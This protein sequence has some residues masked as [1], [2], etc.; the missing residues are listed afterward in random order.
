M[1]SSVVCG[2]TFVVCQTF[3]TLCLDVCPLKFIVC[4]KFMDVYRSCLI[5]SVW[6]GVS[7]FKWQFFDDP[8]SQDHGLVTCRTIDGTV[9]FVYV[10]FTA[11]EINMFQILQLREDAYSQERLCWNLQGF[12]LC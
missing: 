10:Y 7:N 11:R 6:Y 2:R 9:F 12:K 8:I 1:I 4:S 5:G 3:F